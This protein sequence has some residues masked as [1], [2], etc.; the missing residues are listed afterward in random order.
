LSA[1][2]RVLDNTSY[3][4]KRAAQA[5]AAEARLDAL[6]AQ[7]MRRYSAIEQ[8]VRRLRAVVTLNSE[9]TVS[10]ASI[11]ELLEEVALS[12]EEANRIR[13]TDEEVKCA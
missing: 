4:E 5:D 2:V 10:R 13:A 7:S 8:A 1:V 12:L 11:D 6:V 3:L 9:R